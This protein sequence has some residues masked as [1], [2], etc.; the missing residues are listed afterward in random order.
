[1]TYTVAYRDEVKV[2]HKQKEY[3]IGLG[4]NIAA[5]EAC[6][7]HDTIWWYSKDDAKRLIQKL[8]AAIDELDEPT[9]HDFSP[10]TTDQFAKLY[11]PERYL[12]DK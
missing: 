8:Q 5:D 9:E 6:Q 4:I 12:K 1:M 2:F 3:P 11:P 7:K 10:I